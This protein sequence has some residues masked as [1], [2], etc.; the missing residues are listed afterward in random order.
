MFSVSHTG[1]HS[2]T[3][4]CR[5]DVSLLKWILTLPVHF[6]H[7]WYHPANL[8]LVSKLSGS[9]LVFCFYISLFLDLNFCWQWDQKRHSWSKQTENESLCFVELDIYIF[10][11]YSYNVCSLKVIQMPYSASFST[12]YKNRSIHMHKIPPLNSRHCYINRVHHAIACSCYGNGPVTHRIKSK[13]GC[14]NWLR[15]KKKLSIFSEYKK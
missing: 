8:L 7:P 14:S 5:L 10:F 6:R 11:F 9:L 1:D 15:G 4:D 13:Y 3:A 12:H 2:C